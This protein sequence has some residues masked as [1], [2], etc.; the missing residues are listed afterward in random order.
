MGNGQ[1]E[2]VN[3]AKK[4][5]K[6]KQNENEGEDG[7]GDGDGGEEEEVKKKN[8]KASKKIARSAKGKKRKTQEEEHSE[9]KH[10]K[11]NKEEKKEIKIEEKSVVHNPNTNLYE[12]EG[13]EESAGISKKVQSG[14][15]KSHSIERDRSLD[16]R[17]DQK[18]NFKKR[19]LEEEKKEKETKLA[20]D[21]K[22]KDENLKMVQERKKQ[23]EEISHLLNVQKKEEE[24]RIEKKRQQL[25]LEEQKLQAL[26]RE[27]DIKEA[28]I[29]EQLANEISKRQFTNKESFDRVSD[30]QSLMSISPLKLTTESPSLLEESPKVI[31][32]RKIERERA[33]QEL[34]EA[35]KVI[36][37]QEIGRLNM[38]K[39][40][41]EDSS[42]IERNQ[43]LILQ[44]ERAEEEMKERHKFDYRSFPDL[45]TPIDK[46][47]EIYPK[48]PT[49][50]KDTI[51]ETKVINKELES[52]DKVY[53]FNEEILP[54]DTTE[55]KEEVKVFGVLDNK[56]DEDNVP[57]SIEIPL[58]CLNFP[59][60]QGTN[61]LLYAELDKSDKVYQLKSILGKEFL[62]H[63][64]AIRIFYKGAELAD[65]LII[66]LGHFRG[67]ILTF[68][69]GVPKLQLPYV[70]AS[71]VYET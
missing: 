52:T 24:L 64:K 4:R 23:E 49:I 54:P 61:G 42:D 46:S 69:I 10:N 20:L 36:R 44:R 33:R 18:D 66:S 3:K 40:N 16:E 65:Q 60:P 37:D 9:K 38:K 45:G 35:Q 1:A 11:I 32:K 5:R 15:E 13:E 50:K 28:L 67:E 43:L 17:A 62:I 7:D 48:T 22:R 8:K 47:T 27:S 14:E 53:K 63:P 70:K 2:A 29:R 30:K 19:L 25:E 12:F 51:T 57:N 56:N 68:S 34:I 58:V 55:I 71:T 39:A 59:L 21:A 6:K 41:V 26:Q 31:E